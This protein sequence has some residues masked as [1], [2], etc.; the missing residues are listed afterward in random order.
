MSVLNIDVAKLKKQ[1]IYI[2]L[3]RLIDVIA[4]IAGLIILSPLF[5]V[6]A[7]CIK[8]DDPRGPIFYSQ[9]RVGKS[10]RKFRMFKFRSMVTNADQL[11]K[12][13]EE[14]NE[15]DGAMFKLKSDPRITKVGRIIRKYSLDEL[16]QLV[17]VVTGSMS[18]VGPRPPLVHEVEKYSD[19]DKQRLLV[20]PGCTGL[21]QVGGRNDVD[22]DEMVKLDLNYITHRSTFL[23]IKIM[24]E[25]VWVMVKPNGAY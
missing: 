7:L 18:L 10:G 24:F 4:S 8:I 17:N 13:L 9:I 3:K 21:W 19:Y 22:F 16:P 6:V 23:D 12:E 20:K 15:I 1:Y 25:T 2:F 14:K 5:L 11:L